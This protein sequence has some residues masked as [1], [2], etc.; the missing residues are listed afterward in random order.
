MSGVRTDAEQDT[1]R[2]IL[3]PPG[4]G[5]WNMALDE[6]LL[7]S[8]A[9]TGRATL[10]LYRWQA[11]TLSLGYFQ[12]YEE[13]WGHEPSAACPVVRR[14]SGGGAILHDREL[15]YSFTAVIGDRVSPSVQ[16]LYAIF[17][18]TLVDVLRSLGAEA[19]R[20]P[21]PDPATSAAAPFLCFQRRAE[22]DVVLRGAKVCG[23]AQ[24]RRRRAVLQ[25]GS[26]FSRDP[27]SPRNFR[28][29]AT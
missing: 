24:R 10:R 20:W 7:E 27:T 5:A 8:A 16:A 19:E 14:S 11:P 23:S 9:E 28:G 22:G 15:T 3:D 2:L 17:H 4:E 13:R 29:C 18:A 12:R 6:A 26:I 1:V 25:H 21:G